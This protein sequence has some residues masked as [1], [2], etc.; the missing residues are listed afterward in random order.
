[1]ETDIRDAIV[2]LKKKGYTIIAP[3]NSIDEVFEE[4]L[5]Y[6]KLTKDDCVMVG[7]IATPNLTGNNTPATVSYQLV[8]DYLR[9]YLGF[10]GLIITDSLLMGAVTNS[11]TSAEVCIGAVKAGCDILLDPASFTDAFE[12]I[13]KAVE[14][15]EISE[16]RLDESVKRI[17][18]FKKARHNALVSV[19]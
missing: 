15:G 10:E 8:T 2:L 11:Y 7:H 17:L 14:N 12:A 13:V 9:N 5:A 1:M 3:T 16:E 6:K 18:E 4:W 19:G